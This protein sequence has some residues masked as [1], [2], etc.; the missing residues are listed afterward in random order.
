VTRPTIART[1]GPLVGILLTSCGTDVVL[2]DRCLVDLAPISARTTSV[3]VGDTVTFAAALGPAECLPAGVEPPE[4]RWSS[5]DTLIVTIDSLSGLARAVSPGT[6][7]I[8]VVHARQ[9][10]VASTAVLTVLALP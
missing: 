7:L 6:G 10:S 3:S 4:W 2:D 8:Q 9:R 5:S 1:L